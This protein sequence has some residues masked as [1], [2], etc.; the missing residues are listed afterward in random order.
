ME[1]GC[2][3]SLWVWLA[4]LCTSDLVLGGCFAN[5]WDVLSSGLSPVAKH[6][7]VVLR[8]LERFEGIA[9]L[10]WQLYF[11]FLGDL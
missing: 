1:T 7:L 3:S 2:I 5:S 4:V 6:R 8:R 10:V 9:L 11:R